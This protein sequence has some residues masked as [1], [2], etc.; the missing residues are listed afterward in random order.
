MLRFWTSSFLCAVLCIAAPAA[1]QV[2]AAC[3][4]VSDAMLKA[5]TTPHHIRSTQSGRPET[6]EIIVAGDT[7]YV[8]SKG[9]WR[10][11]PMTPV[12]QRA[13]EEENI[14]NARVYT[15]QPLRNE[16]VNG[17]PA[18][19]YKVHTESE[20]GKSDGQVWVAPSLGL[21]VRSEI[22]IDSMGPKMHTV[23]TWDYA[24][25]KAPVIK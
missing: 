16:T 11:S 20:V 21:P 25:I 18:V 19:V 17:V 2:S 24:N 3:K 7:T 1:A 8:M 10:K 9:A 12:Q 5:S 6:G 23:I 22:D 13:Q 14:K 15:C 4:P